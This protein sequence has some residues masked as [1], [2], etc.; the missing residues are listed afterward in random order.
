[1]KNWSDKQTFKGVRMRSFK[2][3]NPKVPLC[4]SLLLTILFLQ[5]AICAADIVVQ[6]GQGISF[7]QVN[8]TW[9]PGAEPDSDR[10]FV[11]VDIPTLRDA[12]E[13]QSGFINI[14]TSLGWVVQNLSVFAEFPYPTNSTAFQISPVS[15]IDITSLEAYVLFSTDPL[16]SS[17]I[18]SGPVP[19]FPVGSVDINAQG[20]GII[21]EIEILSTPSGSSPGT[22][23]P[24][25]QGPIPGS[26]PVSFKCILPPHKG[27]EAKTNQCVP[28]S[29]ANSFQWLK[30]QLGIPFPFLHIE[31]EDGKPPASLVG[32]LDVL[33]GRPKNV[34]TCT[35]QGLEGKLEFLSNN[36]LG[37][38]IAVQHQDDKFFCGGVGGGNFTRHSLTSIGRGVP[39]T[40][41]IQNEVCRGEDVEIWYSFRK[42]DGSIGG[43]AVN[44]VGT[45]TVLGVPSITFITDFGQNAPGGISVVTSSLPTIAG[46]PRV[47]SQLK[48][49]LD[50]VDGTVHHVISE[51]VR[52]IAAV[53]CFDRFATI[54]GTIGDDVLHGTLGDDVIVGLGGNDAIA[55]KGGNDL[56]CG[57]EGNDIISG[58]LGDDKID[59]GDGN[60]SIN[61]GPGNDTI[62]GGAGRDVIAGKDGD[63]KI[64]GGPDFDRIDGGPHILLDD[65]QNGEIVVR[66]NP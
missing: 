54:I 41:F 23:P 55:G 65:C 3:I 51:S 15:G 64:D 11:E 19:T 31:G 47:I 66:C 26:I 36:G 33:M 34:G 28:E 39:T 59:G 56:I 4:V 48:S 44:I 37:G 12:T 25:F 43:H 24:T 27:V 35:D 29:V 1:M 38:R 32:N 62:F 60:D 7:Q 42:K 20:A 50:P 5:S 22:Q 57:N 58:D 49:T 18:P 46:R 30:D 61:G 6:P 14:V 45:E 13:M 16:S 53:R 9:E 63:D 21:E 52:G 40:A 17:P 8:F 2:S 10:G